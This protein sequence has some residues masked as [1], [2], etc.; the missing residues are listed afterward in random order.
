MKPAPAGH[1]GSATRTATFAA[2]MA[3]AGTLALAGWL[4]TMPAGFSSAWG[5]NEPGLAQFRALWHVPPASLS[6]PAYRI[7]FWL[8]LAAAWTGYGALVAVGVR[9]GRVPPRAMR[10]LAVLTVA[11]LALGCPPALSADVYG[12]VGFGRLAALHH[13]NPMTTSQSALVR[14][15]DP[16]APFLGGDVASPYGP[17]WSV[18]SVAVVGAGTGAGVAGQVLGFKLLA[19]AALLAAAAAARQAARA[20]GQPGDP[21]GA[22]EAA[23]AFVALNPLLLI[24]GPGSGHNDLVM[25]ALVVGSFAA[26]RAGSTRLAAL[27]AGAGAA[28]KLVP[29]LLVPWLAWTAA[30]GAPAP[31]SAPRQAARAL[32]TAAL[33]LVPLLLSALPFWDGARTF[34]GLAAWWREGHRGGGGTAGLALLPVAYA[35]ISWT[36]VR[37]SRDRTAGLATGWA[38]ASGAAIALGTA[39][40]FPWYLSWPLAGLAVRCDRR[41]ALATAA[42]MLLAALLTALYAG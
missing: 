3:A 24:E 13:L 32:E 16:V 30:R 41:H 1:T 12:Y 17:L 15:G 20:P 31:A 42:L 6:A 37:T 14:L 10:A 36:L 27:A 25:L 9:G 7:G 28:V 35:V 18:L 29:L 21:T 11:A 22:G 38:L 33:A 2:G 34:A 5:L 19:G 26:V 23:F 4:Y 40:W 8:L 39:T